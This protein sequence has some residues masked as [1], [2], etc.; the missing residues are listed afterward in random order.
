MVK[1]DGSFVENLDHESDYRAFVRAL[2]Q[3]SRELG[4]ETVA[5]F[6]QTDSTA[7]MLRSWGC[8]YLQ[9]ALTG[10]GE[11]SERATMTERRAG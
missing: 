10:M 2:L 9:G 11:R 3:L 1:I 8:D 7:E 6:V 5:E 4:L